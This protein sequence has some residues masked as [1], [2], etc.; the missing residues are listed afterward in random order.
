M[1]WQRRDLV[2]SPQ[3]MLRCNHHG[4]DI[5][6][7]IWWHLTITRYFYTFSTLLVILRLSCPY[8]FES[9]MCLWDLIQI[10]ANIIIYKPVESY[11]THFWQV[12]NA[13]RKHEEIFRQ[14]HWKTLHNGRWTPVA[15]RRWTM[16]MSILILCSFIISWMFISWWGGVEGGWVI[17]KDSHLH[18]VGHF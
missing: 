5:T 15:P 6:K 14:M 7:K 11:G 4:H 17:W 1:G 2:I 8:M 9:L 3:W 12:N 18:D 13:L 10:H 16:S